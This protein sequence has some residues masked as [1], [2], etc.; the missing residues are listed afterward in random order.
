MNRSIHA[1]GAQI[2]ARKEMIDDPCTLI[3]NIC[4]DQMDGLFTYT[5]HKKQPNVG[6]YAIH[7]SYGYKLFV[8][9]SNLNYTVTMPHAVKTLSSKPPWG[10][11]DVTTW[12]RWVQKVRCPMWFFYRSKLKLT[13]NDRKNNMF[14]VLQNDDLLWTHFFGPLKRACLLVTSIWGIN[15]DHFQEAG[16]FQVHPGHLT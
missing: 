10:E 4:F 8:A 7:G 6:K 2:K 13:K 14:Q 15:P 3:F 16:S 5:Y 9:F 12:R 11:G 1:E